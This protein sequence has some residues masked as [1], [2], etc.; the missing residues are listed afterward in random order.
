MSLFLGCAYLT[1]RAVGEVSGATCRRTCGVQLWYG[2]AKLAKST[3]RGQ[4]GS[5]E[6]S[7]RKDTIAVHAS[8]IAQGSLA[9]ASLQSTVGT[10]YVVHAADAVRRSFATQQVAIAAYLSTQGQRARTGCRPDWRGQRGH[11]E[12]YC[13]HC[14]LAD[15]TLLPTQPD[16]SSEPGTGSNKRR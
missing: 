3:W 7:V 6:I 15:S 14:V 10:A 16:P 1:A 13:I 4:R 9:C 2:G 8:E 12:G 11:T 5:F